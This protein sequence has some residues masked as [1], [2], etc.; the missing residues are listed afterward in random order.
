M[1][2]T[3][4]QLKNYL[5]I[6]AIAALIPIA[7]FATLGFALQPVNGDLT[8]LGRL[9]ERDFGWSLPQP[10]V[11]IRP[12]VRLEAPDVIVF[13]DSFSQPNVWQTVVMEKTKLKLLTFSFLN[14]RQPGCIEQWLKSMSTR[15]P[16]AKT[17]LIETTEKSFVERF[18][19]DTA[20]CKGLSILPYAFTPGSTAAQRPLGYKDMMPDPI[21]AIRAVFNS[22][23]KL[24]KTTRSG[25]TIIE[26]LIRSDLFSNQRSDLLLYYKKEADKKTWKQVNIESAL[27]R[28]LALQNIAAAQSLKF[29]INI[30]PDKSSI[31]APFFKNPDVISIL[32]SLQ[33]QLRAQGIAVVDLLPT[34]N[35][36]AVTIKDLYLPND[37]H[38]STRGYILMGETIAKELLTN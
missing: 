29:I 23:P 28:V 31:Y 27:K 38:L 22:K 5:V 10:I 2:N 37:T 26:P 35:A 25:D 9:A 19:I 3:D 15:Y 36:N 7:I 13:G 30:V 20:K 18:N 16:S 24:E 8:R 33:Q 11:E 6:F 1:K 34:L 21:Y 32:P 14:M 4:Q 17:I 12:A